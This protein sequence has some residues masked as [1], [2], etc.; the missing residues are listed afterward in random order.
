MEGAWPC[1]Q[2]KCSCLINAD[3]PAA[4]AAAAAAAVCVLH[5]AA[6]AC[7]F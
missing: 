4:A 3:V 1:G 7:L 5:V 2:V 6:A